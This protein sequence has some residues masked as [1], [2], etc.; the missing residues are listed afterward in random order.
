MRYAF[1]KECNTQ[2]TNK[3]Q[4]L[5]LNSWFLVLENKGISKNVVINFARSIITG[6]FPCNWFFIV[7]DVFSLMIWNR[8]WKN[9]Q[10]TPSKSSLTACALVGKFSSC[11]NYFLM[12]SKF[13]DSV[14][15]IFLI[16]FKFSFL[17]FSTC[18]RK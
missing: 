2:E 8:K 12:F 5:L 16:N 13:P 15:K 3:N 9:L 18:S 1:E 10:S 17:D 11:Y 7:Y 4:K 6:T 14:V